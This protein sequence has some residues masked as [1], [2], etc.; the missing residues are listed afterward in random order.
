M[1]IVNSKILPAPKGSS[2]N[3]RRVGRGSGSGW[4]CTAG[5]GN[6]GAKSRSGYSRRMG[7]EGGQT[8]LVRRT[9]KF[10]FTNAPFKKRVSVINVGDLEKLGSAEIKREDLVKLGILPT[11]KDYIKLLSMGEVK[12]AIKITVDMASKKAVEKITKAGGEVIINKRVKWIRK[13]Q[14]K[15]K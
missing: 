10:G 13:V 6:K 3:R 12:S 14:K 9:P 2:K 8:S 11:A 1:S 4:G 15:S 5:R 7:F